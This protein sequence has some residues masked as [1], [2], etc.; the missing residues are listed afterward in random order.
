MTC[1]GSGALFRFRL[2]GAK[3]ASVLGILVSL[4]SGLHSPRRRHGN[5]RMAV[6]TCIPLFSHVKSWKPLPRKRIPP[7]RAFFAPSAGAVGSR[8][9]L[10]LDHLL[11]RGVKQRVAYY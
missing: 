10:S 1:I 5:T 2:S 6:D 8:T 4:A 11:P 3:E 9:G 7:R